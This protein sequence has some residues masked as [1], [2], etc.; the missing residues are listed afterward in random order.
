[1]Y[2][3]VHSHNSPHPDIA[4][5]LGSLGNVYSE[6]GLLDKALERLEESLEMYEMV[7]GREPHL[8]IATTLNSLGIVY[9][10]MG[11][12]DKTLELCERS[13]EMHRA[14]HGHVKP[15]LDIA[16]SLRNV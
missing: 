13:L 3:A 10:K 2:R 14:V 5:S 1:M 16:G 11:K 4:G 9:S 7:H 6:M 15:H 12:P 8:D